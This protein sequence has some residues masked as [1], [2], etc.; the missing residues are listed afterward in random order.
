MGAEILRHRIRLTRFCSFT[1]DVSGSQQLPLN[2]N[3]M[4]CF[5]KETRENIY[6]PPRLEMHVRLRCLLNLKQELHN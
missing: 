4:T 3:V 2:A 1:S 5:N 6:E